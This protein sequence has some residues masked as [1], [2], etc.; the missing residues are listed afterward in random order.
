MSRSKSTTLRNQ[1]LGLTATAL[2]GGT[3][4]LRSGPRPVAGPQAADAGTLLAVFA[5][6]GT[7]FTSPSGGSMSLA[8][9]PLVED[10]ALAT[11]VAGHLRFKDSGGAG[12][13][14]LRV[15]ATG[16][17]GE[18]TMPSTTVTAGEPVQV[19]V[20]TFTEPVGTAGD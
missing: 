13:E 18:A 17:G 5:L 16:G 1:I 8:D 12:V 6:D 9:V 3:A 20:G 2:A 14:D 15:T 7:P 10:S 4:E 19:T 11:G